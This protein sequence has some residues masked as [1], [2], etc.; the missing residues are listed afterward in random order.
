MVA[1]REPRDVTSRA[2]SERSV[3]GWFR[4]GDGLP[5]ARVVLGATLYLDEPHLWAQ[6][7]AAALLRAF[8]EVAPRER[9]TAYTTTKLRGWQAV[10]GHDLA[11]LPEVLSTPWISKR[12]RH[13]FSFRLADTAGAPA[14]GFAY[15]E[16]DPGRT[17]RCSWIQLVLPDD[18]DPAALLRLVRLAG[19][20]WTLL[21]AT[22]GYQLSLQ[23][24]PF[25]TRRG[26]AWSLC[27]RYL[28]L[29]VPDPETHC[30]YARRGLLGVGWL[31]FLGR[32]LA[33]AIEADL[34]ALGKER[35]EDGGRVD[36]LPGGLLFRTGPEPTL[37]DAHAL[38]YPRAHA[39]VARRLDALLVAPAPSFHGEADTTAWRDR[40][41]APDGW[42]W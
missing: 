16:V 9:L 28:C 35:F 33:D 30:Q 2:V 15:H 25:D 5:I 4:R 22:A 23:R 27:K 8:L 10:A 14:C 18:A 11:H 20:E 42:S 37:G 29:D 6:E 31:T 13:C 17:D 26:I 38:V 3:D 24:E 19:G 34:E 39:E 21:S 12:L 32:R 40:F 36:E 7:G 41:V 1:A